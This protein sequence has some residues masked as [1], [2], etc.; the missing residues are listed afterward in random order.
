[1]LLMPDPVVTFAFIIATLI[2]A[3]F[4][5]VVGGDAR[6]LAIFLVAAWIGFGLGHALGNTL[7]IQLLMIGELRMFPATVGAMFALFIAF[8]LTT[9]RSTQRTTR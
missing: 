6:R 1:M 8:I 7:D 4:H 5:F 3:I 9:S 2:G